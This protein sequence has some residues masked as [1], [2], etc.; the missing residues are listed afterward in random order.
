MFKKFPLIAGSVAFVLL[1]ALGASAPA[2][3][4]DVSAWL[5]GADVVPTS[6]SDYASSSFEESLR[7]LKATGATYVSLVVPYYQSNIYST[8]IAPGY[9]TPT[10]SALASAIDYAHSIG[11]KVAL[12]MH[13]D[14]YTGDWR[15]NINPSDR[16]TWFQNYGNYLTHLA[17]LGQAHGVEL[18]IIGSEL[19]DMPTYAQNGDNTAEWE[20][21]I[22]EV[23]NVYSGQLTY[24]ANSD[25][26]ESG[27]VFQD[28]K[29][30]IGFWN[31]L[32]YAGISAYYNLNTQND[33]VSSLE[34]QWDYWN[35]ADLKPFSQKV[36]KPILFVE[37]GYR[38]VDGAHEQ[39][40]NWQ[41]GGNANETEQQNDYQALFSYWNNYP[42]IAGVLLW[43]WETNPNGGGSGNTDYTPQNKPAEQTITQWFTQGSGGSQSSG[44]YSFSADSGGAPGSGTAGSSIS[45]T[46]NVHDLGAALNGG[47]V[48]IEVYDS[49]NSRV[50][51]KYVSASLAAGS[52]QTFTASWTPNVAGAYR[53]AVG[54]FSGDWSQ[55]YYWNNSAASISIGGSSGGGNGNTG[56]NGSTTPPASGSVDV[57]WPTDGAHVSGTQPFKAMIDDTDVSQYQMYWQVGNGQ[58]NLM[59]NNSTD[60]PHKESDV[61]L[62]QW[63]WEGNGPYPITFTAVDGTDSTIAQKTLN[64]W[65]P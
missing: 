16:T 22:S 35:G 4:A 51:Q 31:D 11:L 61:D 32:D 39:P 63:N 50:F 10:D 1:P 30:Y 49:N 28:E 65:V 19:V 2:A 33:D 6:T 55:N 52:S 29:D 17:T 47:I 64:I 57:W 27:G 21:L 53:M 37:V 46:A 26:N 20:K 34:G 60:Y 48:D 54:V 41:M 40:W 15:A 62:S 18:I 24:D 13:V 7:S 38:S 9:N 58:K 3:H 8:D 56:G 44:S 36:G 25:N 45:L 14:P 23:R 42:Y 5:R 59:Q 12:D 43:D